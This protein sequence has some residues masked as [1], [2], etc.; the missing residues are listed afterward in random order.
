MKATVLRILSLLIAIT[1][2]F[3]IFGCSSETVKETDVA[4]EIYEKGDSSRKLA[5]DKEYTI[6]CSSFYKTSNNITDALMLIKEGFRKSLGIEATYSTEVA[7]DLNESDE[8]VILLGPSQRQASKEALEELGIY[9]YTYEIVSENV[10]V[11]CGGTTDATLLAAEK[12]CSEVLLYED[13]KVLDGESGANVGESYTYKYKYPYENLTLDGTDIKDFKIAIKNTSELSMAEKLLDAF[14][15]YTGHRIPI[16]TFDELEGNEKGVI[17]YKAYSRDGLEKYEAFADG[18]VMRFRSD[19]S[20]I[21]IGIDYIRQ[22]YFYSVLDEFKSKSAKSENGSSL[23]L[24]LPTYDIRA[25]N[26]DKFYK[27][28]P[29]WNLAEETVEELHDG[30]T[31]IERKYTDENALP[32]KAYILLIDPSKY[33]IYMGTAADEYTAYPTA[34][35]SVVGHM[36]SAVKNNVNVVA[37]VNGDFFRIATDYGPCGLAIKEGKFLQR[38]DENRPYFAFTK[39]GKPII[40]FHGKD[41]DIDSIKT[42]VS[43]RQVLVHDGLPYDV[44]MNDSFGTTAHPRT[45]S[46]IKS[47]GTIILAVIDGRQPEISNGAPLAQCA[48]FMISLGAVEAVNHDGGGSS[49]MVIRNG[50]NY[51]VK[52]SP[53]DGAPRN[54]YSSLLVV[55]ND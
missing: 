25:Y 30:L 4:T 13:G 41:A 52:N 12:F 32:Y 53:S 33:S 27:G 40:G 28:L 51:N 15:S 10:V 16:V 36:K 34:R 39:D 7:G 21:T 54:V 18:A 11:I 23:D 45:L 14:A 44:A 31:Y 2:L 6:V 55:A 49:T 1:M 20:G 46:G 50:N 38:V 42:C 8:Y 35:E 22:E 9:D 43:G 17:C 24:T 26:V 3:S 37:G 48:R 47:D 5:L 19:S 29:T